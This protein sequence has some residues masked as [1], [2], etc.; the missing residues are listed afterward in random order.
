MGPLA[1]ARCGGTRY[2]TRMHTP[3]LILTVALVCAA[4]SARAADAAAKYALCQENPALDHAIFVVI[5]TPNGTGA[6]KKWTFAFDH[7]SLSGRERL[8]PM[9][10]QRHYDTA[11]GQG[12]SLTTQMG[13]RVSTARLYPALLRPKDLRVWT[14]ELGPFFTSDLLSGAVIDAG[15]TLKGTVTIQALKPPPAAP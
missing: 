3:S 14:A 11:D 10:V 13:S 8:H 4:S 6:A 7:C 9:E 5:L 1:Q 2:H 12:F 15:P